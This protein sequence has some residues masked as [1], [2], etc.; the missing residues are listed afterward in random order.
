MVSGTVGESYENSASVTSSEPFVPD[1][2]TATVTVAGRPTPPKDVPYLTSSLLDTSSTEC[3]EQG[4]Q[5]T[6][7]L[8][9]L[10]PTNENHDNLKLSIALP[11]GLKYLEA[12]G[13]RQLPL[14]KTSGDGLTT[15]TWDDLTID[16]GTEEKPTKIVIN[17]QLQVGM[18]WDTLH[19]V[20]TASLPSQTIPTYTWGPDGEEY[21]TVVEVCPPPAPAVGKEVDHG[22]REIGDTAV[23]QITLVNNKPEDISGIM[24]EDMLPE[25]IEF[26]EMVGEA[27]FPDLRPNLDTGTPDKHLMWNNLSV[28][29]REDGELVATTILQYKVRL[30]SGE[31]GESYTN[32]V[33][34]T[35]IEEFDPAT[36]SATI[37]AIDTPD[38]G[39]AYIVDSISQTTASAGCF[40]HNDELTYDVKLYSTN[41]VRDFGETTVIVKLP[42]GLKYVGLD[43]TTG[44]VS[45]PAPSVTDY[46]DGS[47]WLV[48]DSITLPKMMNG[49]PVVVEFPVRLKVGQVWG[50]LT[51]TTTASS[52]QTTIF[53]QE[54]GDTTIEPVVNICSIPPDSA[55][56]GKEVGAT[57]VVSGSAVMYHISLANTTGNDI[58][59]VTVEDM[60]PE[61]AEFI[62]MI[63]SDIAPLIETDPI[64]PTLNRRLV[65][66]NITVPAAEDGEAMGLLTLKYKLRIFGEVDKSYPNTAE[67]TSDQGFNPSSSS[68]TV[69]VVGED[70]QLPPAGGLG[71]PPYFV[72]LPTIHSSE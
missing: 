40:E 7:Q 67:V 11:V 34:V 12:T 37:T 21:N 18:V 44:D 31:V 43:T 45:V 55:A 42:M 58:T 8:R 19:P 68:A 60:L 30:A 15:L 24:L 33:T 56:I 54:N 59:D 51:P 47:T 71:G 66:R 17:V 39:V 26:V 28:P 50:N 61:G 13:A 46:I 9:L 41:T 65:W 35:A 16:K 23:Y 49:L 53:E 14:V 32:T 72:F 29:A 22:S 36:S 70:S 5:L 2:D 6:Y 10:N 57:D 25:N 27:P 63:G 4:A 62:T 1:T 64:S 52:P 38:D 48:W 69:T 3:V 20:A